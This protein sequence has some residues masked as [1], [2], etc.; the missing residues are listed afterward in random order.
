MAFQV[1]LTQDEKIVLG[2]ASEKPFVSEPQDEGIALAR[3]DNDD[4]TKKQIIITKIRRWMQQHNGIEWDNTGNVS[5][6]AVQRSADGVNWQTVY[7]SPF[8]AP[9]YNDPL[10]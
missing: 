4:E 10:L 1:F 5:S 8:T 3:Y 6:Y 9:N 2:G 7:R